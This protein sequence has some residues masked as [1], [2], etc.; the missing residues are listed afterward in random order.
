MDRLDDMIKRCGARRSRLI[1]A[2]VLLGPVQALDEI[3]LQPPCAELALRPLAKPPAEEGEAVVPLGGPGSHSVHSSDAMPVRRRSNRRLARVRVTLIGRLGV[4]IDGPAR[5]GFVAQQP[6]GV[7]TYPRPG[8]PQAGHPDPATMPA[9][10][11]QSWGKVAVESLLAYRRDAAA[12]AWKTRPSEEGGRGC[13]VDRTPCATATA[14]S[15]T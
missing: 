8:E 4:A 15:P 12:G 3:A 9:K 7:T 1:R 5:P 2:G 13:C 6:L 14:G 10:R 11:T